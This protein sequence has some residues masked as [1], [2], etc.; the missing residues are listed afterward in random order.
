MRFR[1]ENF[2]HSNRPEMTERRVERISREMM[3]NERVMESIRN[4]I[5]TKKDFKARITVDDGT[6]EYSEWKRLG[7]FIVHQHK[8]S[9]DLMKI[10]SKND[11]KLKAGGDVLELHVP[12]QK[13]SIA[14]IKKPF[15]RIKEY[16][17]YNRKKGRDLPEYIYG[18]SY[19]ASFTE[20]WGFDVVDLP[21]DVKKSS[22]A[23]N[24]LRSYAG[25]ED[26]TKKR[27]SK[28]Y[29][30]DDI[31]FCYIATNDLLAP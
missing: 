28:N 1:F 25:A 29:S 11:I 9:K 24:V 27:I 15:A 2:E 13:A 18:V 30:V 7:M 22:G 6:N 16:L 31:K 4:K 10:L 14:D 5:R 17:E 21:E 19:L 26:E 12:L 8:L 23:A 20:R 3:E